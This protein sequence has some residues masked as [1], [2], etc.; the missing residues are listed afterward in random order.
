MFGIFGL[1]KPKYDSLMVEWKN[2]FDRGMMVLET[3][4]YDLDSQNTLYSGRVTVY[5]V[6]RVIEYLNGKRVQERIL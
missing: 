6:Y 4:K 5:N 3:N 2:S 1:G